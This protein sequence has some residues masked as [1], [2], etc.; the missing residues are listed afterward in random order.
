[1][2]KQDENKNKRTLEAIVVGAGAA[3]TISYSLSFI[4]IQLS[5]PPYVFSKT[6]A[7]GG[8]SHTWLVGD[9]HCNF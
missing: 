2:G 7:G 8:D 4:R 3:D 9:A 5:K 1:M 6:R